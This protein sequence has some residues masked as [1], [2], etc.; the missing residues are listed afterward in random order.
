MTRHCFSTEWRVG[1]STRGYLYPSDLQAVITVP[2]GAHALDPSAPGHCVLL[3]GQPSLPGVPRGW[4]APEGDNGA[5]TP[6]HIP[7]STPRPPGDQDSGILSCGMAAAPWGVSQEAPARRDVLGSTSHTCCVQ[8]PWHRDALRALG[9]PPADCRGRRAPLSV[10]PV[11][12]L[13]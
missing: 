1:G 8:N 9:H 2:T 13:S 3:E 11:P 4:A 10:P 5:Q 6:L 12:E 7:S